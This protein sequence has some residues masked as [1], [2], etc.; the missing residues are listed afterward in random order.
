MM[1]YNFPKVKS[2]SALGKASNVIPAKAEIRV[3]IFF[4]WIA[5]KLHFVLGLRRNGVYKIVASV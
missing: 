3:V 4:S 5:E 2:E 1:H